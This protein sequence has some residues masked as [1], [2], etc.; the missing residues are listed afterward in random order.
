MSSARSSGAS[1]PSS[2]SSAGA[3]ARA[4]PSSSAASSGAGSAGGGG[5]AGGAASKQQVAEARALTKLKEDLGELEDYIPW[6][7]VVPSWGS[8][9]SQWAKKI[10]E[11]TDVAAVGKLLLAL[12]QARALPPWPASL[13]GRP[14]CAPLHGPSRSHM[15]HHHHHG[16]LS[17]CLTRRVFGCLGLPLTSLPLTSLPLTAPAHLAPAHR[18]R[19][20]RRPS[21]SKR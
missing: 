8:R 18:S 3:S 7:A 14:P 5:G 17:P 16:P 1:Q 19:P 13:A 9:R 20:P 21:P 4:A 12:E 2:K 15:A 10:K 6:N 11:S